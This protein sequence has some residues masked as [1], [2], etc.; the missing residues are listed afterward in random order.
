M[1]AC[2]HLEKTS[3]C[4]GVGSNFALVG[5]KGVGPGKKEVGGSPSSPEPL[6]LSA[7]NLFS[8]SADMKRW[9]N[10]EE[11][12][13]ITIKCGR[14]GKAWPKAVKEGGSGCFAAKNF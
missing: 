14:E 2:T 10:T 8:N 6:D 4:R 12:R 1:C 7:R 9:Q 11:D 13:R 5:Q 3:Q